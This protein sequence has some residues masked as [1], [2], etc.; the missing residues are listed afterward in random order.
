MS[1]SPASPD[2]IGSCLVPLDKPIKVE[3]EP[4]LPSDLDIALLAGHQAAATTP[5]AAAGDATAGG[6]SEDGVRYSAR[7]RTCRLGCLRLHMLLV[8]CVTSVS[9]FLSSFAAARQAAQSQLL[10]YSYLPC[11]AVPTL[12]SFQNCLFVQVLVAQGLSSS[13]R[14]AIIRGAHNE[15]G[16]HLANALKFIA[17]K[18]TREGERHGVLCALGGPWDP[19]LDGGD[20]A[21]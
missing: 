12:F 19:Q 3:H 14:D 9:C 6:L 18:V 20:P 5:A 11:A 13:Q 10:K 15:A 1:A 4:T 8:R 17:A 2:A 7:V 21:R 16:T